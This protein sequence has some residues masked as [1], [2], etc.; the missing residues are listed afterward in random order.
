MYTTK[1]RLN[2]KSPYDS[3]L[4]FTVNPNG[5]INTLNDTE[6]LGMIETLI[7]KQRGARYIGETDN[8]NWDYLQTAGMHDQE[9]EVMKRRIDDMF[10]TYDDESWF[11]AAFPIE[12]NLNAVQHVTRIRMN[13][14]LPTKRSPGTKS[15]MPTGDF[16]TFYNKSEWY[17]TNIEFD[18]KSLLTEQGIAD[19]QYQIDVMGE[20]IV[21]FTRILLYKRLVVLRDPWEAYTFDKIITQS[22]LD[23]GKAIAQ[24]T[25]DIYKG[26]MRNWNRVHEENFSLQKIDAIAN[27]NESYFRGN[28]SHWIVTPEV[29]VYLRLYNLN[30]ISNNSVGQYETGSLSG[31]NNLDALTSI[32][33]IGNSTVSVQRNFDLDDCVWNPLKTLSIVGHHYVLPDTTIINSEDKH[34][35]ELGNITISDSKNRRLEEIRYADVNANLINSPETIKNIMELIKENHGNDGKDGFVYHLMKKP[36]LLAQRFKKVHEQGDFWAEVEGGKSGKDYYENAVKS[37]KFKKVLESIGISDPTAKD[38]LGYVFPLSKYGKKDG[39]IRTEY[40]ETFVAKDG[41]TKDTMKFDA[42]FVDPKT[43]VRNAFHINGN[44]QKVKNTVSMSDLVACLLYLGQADWVEL[45]TNNDNFKTGKFP[46]PWGYMLSSSQEIYKTHNG[47]RILPMGGTMKRVMGYSMVNQQTQNGQRIIMTY[48]QK[49][50]AWLTSPEN[51]TRAANMAVKDHVRGGG[52]TLRPQGS[53]ISED[54]AISLQ[55]TTAGDLLVLITPFGEKSPDYFDLTGATNA[56]DTFAITWMHAHASY[57]FGDVTTKPLDPSD[58]RLFESVVSANPNALM[59]NVVTAP[60]PYYYREK[61]GTEK[62]V[63]GTGAWKEL[64]LQIHAYRYGEKE[65][66]TVNMRK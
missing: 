65:Y 16:S 19:L 47:H 32:K 52:V 10:K 43:G 8:I 2:I 51:Y 22:T 48:D 42:L 63:A 39:K 17:G 5:F 28:T 33:A 23:Q 45:L 40:D 44:I 11:S 55:E 7:G 37:S 31:L 46:V 57:G 6:K 21:L 27:D 9:N 64:A 1:A 66:T 13:K 4:P 41:L 29:D 20:S 25:R 58:S 34:N 26:R 38:A 12:V 14:N 60:G 62:S 53:D 15:K 3:Q 36:T 49:H 61:N 18:F 54:K 24:A 35:M 30:H 59:I 50:G 56:D